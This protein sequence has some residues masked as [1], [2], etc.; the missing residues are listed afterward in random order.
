[1]LH[2]D[3]TTSSYVLIAV[4]VYLMRRRSGLVFSATVQVAMIA[5]LPTQRCAMPG[6]DSHPTL[7]EV[8]TSV[9]IRDNAQSC[10][11]KTSPDLRRM[12]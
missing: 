12:R 4:A 3:R 6:S 2:N 7:A 1:M 5:G 10:R 8:S 9:L 11:E